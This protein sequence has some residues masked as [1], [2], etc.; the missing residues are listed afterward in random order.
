MI[1][2]IPA[3]APD[4]TPKKFD[5]PKIPLSPNNLAKTITCGGG[6]NYHPSGERG[7]TNRE[8]ACL[9]TFPLNYKFGKVEVRTQIGNAVPPMLAKALYKAIIKS[10]E[11]TDGLR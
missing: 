7:F 9:Q 4:H 6:E 2:R 8:F 11:E 5:A 10:L 1:S 3:N